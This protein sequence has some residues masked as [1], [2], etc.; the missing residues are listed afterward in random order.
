MKLGNNLVEFKID[1]GADLTVVPKSLYCKGNSH[2]L[3][4]SGRTLFGT[5]QKKL[6]VCGKFQT[7]LALG[8]K[9]TYQDVYIVKDL[10]T[11]LLGRPAIE[12]LDIVSRA[13]LDHI[14]KTGQNIQENFPNLFTGL[15]KIE[16]NYQIQLIPGAVPFSLNTPRRMPLPLL[17]KVKN[18]LKSM[19]TQG[20]IE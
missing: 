15:G 18:E 17:S 11:P 1:T 3:S 20:I 9:V 14:E 16:G 12:A 13:H 5:G 8:E 4:R 10:H 2:R 19:E 7:S 6:E